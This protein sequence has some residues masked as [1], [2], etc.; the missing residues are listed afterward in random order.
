MVMDSQLAGWQMQL[1]H[2]LADSL[3]ALGKSKQQA[4]YTG[5]ARSA[6]FFHANSGKEE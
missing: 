4:M 2:K 6:S 3:R 5:K 1:R